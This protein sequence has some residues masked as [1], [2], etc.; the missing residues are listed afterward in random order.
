MRRIFIFLLS[1]ALF[2]GTSVAATAKHEGNLASHGTVTSI[3]LG[4]ATFTI[5]S[6]YHGTQTFTL[7][8]RAVVEKD[9]QAVGFGA[10]GI[11]DEVKVHYAEG[12]PLE[13]LRVIIEGEPRHK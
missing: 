2:I 5:D 11:K 7:A 3:D 1:L 8:Q 9:G 10:L 13:A 12:S 4:R 6:K